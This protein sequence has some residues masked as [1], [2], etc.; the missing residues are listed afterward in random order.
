MSV[1]W[2]LIAL[3]NAA[4]AGWVQLG[5][6]RGHVLHAAVGEE[7]VA[8]ATRVGVASAG[9]GLDGWAR[10]PR[11]PPEVRRLAYGP[12]D[13][14][15]GAPAGQLWRIG[16][17]TER[18]L[19]FDSRTTAV[20]LATT[21]SGALIAALRG[22][23]A[24]V[25]RVADGEVERVLE[26]VDPWCLAADGE[27]VLLGTVEQGLLSSSD[28]GRSFETLL[29]VGAG[30]SAV[31][32]LGS[33]I[34]LGLADGGLRV[35]REGAW[36]DLPA[37]ERGYAT[38]FAQ[39]PKGVLVTV[40]R[41]SQGHDTMLL[42]LGD[43][44]RE[45]QPGR[46][47][48]DSTVVDLTGAWSLPDGRAMVGSF[49]RG[50]LVY[51][52][53]GLAPAR[54]GFRATV[55]GGAA[56]DESGRIVLALMGTGVYVSEDAGASWGPPGLGAGPVTDSVAVLAH[57]DEVLVVDFEGVTVLDP[58]G[59]WRR[60]PANPLL[61]PGENLVSV[62]FDAADTLWAVDRVGALY[63]LSGET[64][65]ACQQRGFR[66]DGVGEHLVLATP[67]GFLAAAGCDEPWPALAL[68]TQPRIDG[69]H[70]RAS[71]GWVAGGG[72]V[73]KGSEKRFDIPSVSVSAIA[74]RGDEVLVA[75]DGGRIFHCTESCRALDDA[76]PSPVAALGWLPD[77]RIWVA[78]LT[79]TFLV[80][81]DAPPLSPWSGVLDAH[82]VT[83]DL[84]PLERAPWNDEASPQGPGPGPV[85]PGPGVPGRNGPAPV[86]PVV[87]EPS[88]EAGCGC[89]AVSGGAWGLVWL[90]PLVGVWRRWGRSGD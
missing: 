60:L 38:G 32:L 69:R 10:D 11:F 84:M 14:A 18:V 30:V 57:G 13:V 29:E 70:A 15:W 85:V 40:Q 46:M 8:V 42:F 64:W 68:D 39:T 4:M 86:E 53:D 77:G 88:E 51:G 34:W 36:T 50:P 66:L 44:G 25:V 76:V 78:E 67:G 80:Q 89:G 31:A 33:E 56:V 58:E 43:W 90:L 16:E 47:R 1:V 63:Q 3:C 61:K 22:D 9:F 19:F 35:Q 71:Q 81:G 48:D 23:E 21:G 49:R 59:Q 2:P 5:P 75:L 79:G 26:G 65:Q 45:V 41:V 37:I 82:R 17:Q 54:D 62:G 27:R 28:D 24:G 52:E 83:G 74:V 72:A 20:D 6:E 87:P 7:H 55:T 73:W 12:G